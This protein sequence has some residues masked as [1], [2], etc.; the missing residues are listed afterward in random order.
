MPSLRRRHRDEHEFAGAANGPVVTPEAAGVSREPSS[1]SFRPTA[2][3]GSAPP[4]RRQSEILDAANGSGMAPHTEP[5][6]SR[7]PGPRPNTAVIAGL[8]PAPSPAPSTDDVPD[9]SAQLRQLEAGERR[10]RERIAR[11]QAEILS[12]MAP[13][14]EAP[15]AQAPQLTQRDHEFIAARG[16]EFTDPVLLRTANEVQNAGHEWPSDSFYNEMELRLPL[17]QHDPDAGPRLEHELP[18]PMRQPQPAAQRPK[19]VPQ[20][21]SEPHDGEPERPTVSPEAMRKATMYSAPPTREV[22]SS[23]T[24]LPSNSRVT[25]SVAEQEIARASGLSD[26]DY[27]RGKLKMQQAKRDDPEKYR[28]Q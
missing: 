11:T 15:Q 25:L 3:A 26:L 14:T 28:S 7:E 2:A 9:L 8:G 22:A 20:M 21:A 5:A 6:S 17:P 27:A 1:P 19:P 24:G 12:H 13:R 18:H 23:R 10:E 4:Q 16:L